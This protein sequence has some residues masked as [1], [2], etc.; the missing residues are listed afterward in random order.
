MGMTLRSLVLRAAGGHGDRRTSN[1][2]RRFS[3]LEPLEGRVLMSAE[4]GVTAAAFAASGLPAAAAD[5]PAAQPADADLA[6]GRPAVASSVR[7]RRHAPAKVTD[8]NDATHWASARED[9][10]RS[11]LYVDLG[12]AYAL[13]RVT[14][15]WGRARAGRVTVQVADSL[16]AEAADESAWRDAAPVVT[17]NTARNDLS[18]SGVGRYVRIVCEASTRAGRFT[19]N[20]V[21][22]FGAAAPTADATVTDFAAQATSAPIVSGPL[23]PVMPTSDA[24]YGAVVNASN[25]VTGYLYPDYMPQD[26]KLMTDLTGNSQADY[27]TSLATMQAQYPQM[28]IGTY[29]SFRD[30]QLAATMTKYPR[31][32]VPREGLNANQILMKE[33]GNPDADIVNYTQA[34]ARNYLVKNVVQDVTTTGRPLAFL[35]NVSHNENGFPIA[36]STTT[37]VIKDM[38]TKLHAVNKR[39]IVNAAWT[40]GITSTTS[41]DQLIGSGV[42]GVSLEMGFHANVRNSVA[43]IQTAMSQYRRM[44]DTG[45]TVIFIAVGNATGD[46]ATIENTEVEQ[47][48]QAAFGMMFRK[49]GDRLFVNQI[50][51]RPVQEW[52]RWP[53]QFGA[54]VAAAT[55]STNS[56]GQVVMTRQFARTTLTVNVATKEVT[57]TPLT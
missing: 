45:M 9:G 51:W 18:V 21:Q 23:L 32:A 50:F 39:V 55:V 10:G 53:E 27:T 12:D 34:A 7:R 25:Y 42:D 15:D 54:P 19:L 28:L 37:S 43:R 11:W 52:T 29:H 8:G 20:D 56:L 13:D 49:P 30:A 16:P 35:D 31:R 17:G 24:W 26:V 36:W 6:L 22:V 4:V 44:L 41:V 57:Y 14:L 2:P 48:L 1:Q 40:P 46:A 47:R 38:A 5:A 3:P 33:P